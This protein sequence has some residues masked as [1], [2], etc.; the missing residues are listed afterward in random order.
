LTRTI[1]REFGPNGIRA[2]VICPA[3][4]ETKMLDGLSKSRIEEITADIPLRRTG[5]P[6]SVAGACL[7][8]ASDLSE[9]VTGATIDVNGGAHIH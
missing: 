1:A 2:N 3:M 9:Y 8:L 5:R 6:F 7:F 4:I